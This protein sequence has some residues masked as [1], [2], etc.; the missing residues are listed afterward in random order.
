MQGL[1]AVAKEKQK[2]ANFD[3]DALADLQ[4]DFAEVL[5]AGQEVTDMMMVGGQQGMG[6]DVDGELAAWLEDDPPPSGGMAVPGGMGDVPIAPVA[7]GGLPP[8]PASWGAPVP[9]Y[10]GAGGGGGGEA[11]RL[12]HMPMK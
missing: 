4:D 7:A 1:V 6:G 12:A 3:V 2:T 5:N 10:Q 11:P 9:L 8:M